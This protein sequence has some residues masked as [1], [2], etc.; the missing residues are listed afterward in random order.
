VPI[1]QALW[2]HAKEWSIDG[3]RLPFFFNDFASFGSLDL[4]EAKYTGLGWVMFIGH[5]DYCKSRMP[6][7]HFCAST[8][9]MT[10]NPQSYLGTSRTNT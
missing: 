10:P 2:I 1:G 6:L 5:R 8:F 3:N 4:L 9:C 7:S